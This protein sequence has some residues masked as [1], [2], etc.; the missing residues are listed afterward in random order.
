M[1]RR[2]VVDSVSSMGLVDPTN[3]PSGEYEYHS[4]MLTEN[5]YEYYW[6]II[7][8]EILIEFDYTYIVNEK[9]EELLT[10]I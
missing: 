3:T 5:S 9:N 1:V 10:T 4:L 8:K 6:N 2:E 7:T